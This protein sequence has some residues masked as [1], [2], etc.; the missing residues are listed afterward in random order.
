M[1]YSRKNVGNQ[2]LAVACMCCKDLQAENFFSTFIPRDGADSLCI[3]KTTQEFHQ[4]RR[5][6]A[7]KARAE[8]C[9]AMQEVIT[10]HAITHV[11]SIGVCVDFM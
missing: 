10:K 8:E 2:L 3:W 7:D 5:Q 4:R 9:L 1:L 11:S 6:T